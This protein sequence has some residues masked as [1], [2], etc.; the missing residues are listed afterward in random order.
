MCATN[1]S[2]W[3]GFLFAAETGR[4]FGGQAKPLGQFIAR[5]QRAGG[6]GMALRNHLRQF[7]DIAR[8][9]V[10]TE[11]V[12]GLGG[13][14]ADLPAA[15][16]VLFLQQGLGQERQVVAPLGQRQATRW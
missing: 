2:S 15:A 7:G 6:P 4:G 8:P 3:I 9:S 13:E 14:S 10:G 16:G 11:A 12:E 1:S 5:D